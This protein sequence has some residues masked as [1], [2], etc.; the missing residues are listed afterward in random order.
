MY[1]YD[2]IELYNELNSTS[3]TEIVFIN[4]GDV[5]WADKDT[6]I[7]TVLGSCVSVCVWHP[8]KQIG[9]MCHIKMPGKSNNPTVAKTNYIYAHD[10]IQY[11]NNKIKATGL[12][13]NEFIISIYGGSTIIQNTSTLEQIDIGINNSAYAKDMLRRLG[14]KISHEETGGTKNRKIRFDI[15]TGKVEV[16]EK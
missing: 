5:H 13:K 4:S 12:D 3:Y 6:M 16:I 8:E 10:A 7:T 1:W 11:L 2:N 9:G 14:Y 15:K